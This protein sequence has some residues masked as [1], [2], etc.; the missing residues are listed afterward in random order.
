MA[1]REGQVD[2]ETGVVGPVLGPEVRAQALFRDRF[3]AVV[4]PGH[5]F[6]EAPTLT[7]YSAARHVHLSRRGHTEGPVDTALA[8]IGVRRQV[9]AI[10]SGFSESLAL[11]RA[12]DLVATVP[13]RYTGRLRDGLVSVPLP[14]AVPDIVISLLW[15]PRLDADP[16][17]R[18]LRHCVRQVCADRRL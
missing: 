2:L 7:A 5:P 12:T 1:L 4:R 6:A 11:A 17:H 18:W 14:V 3:V 16:A 15:H 8:A 13:E 10:V 9:G